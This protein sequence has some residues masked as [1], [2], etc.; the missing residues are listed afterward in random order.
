MN[1]SAILLSLAV[2][3]GCD[4]PFGPDDEGIVLT[5]DAEA[6]SPGA[7]ITGELRN[8]SSESIGYN[9][10]FSGFYRRRGFD[11]SSVS[12]LFG[13]GLACATIQLGLAPGATARFE[14]ALPSALTAGTYRLQ[15]E[16]ETREGRS[17]R[18]SDSFVIRTS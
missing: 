1:R 15:T 5:V 11:W 9:L 4:N 18:W 14:I 2:L 13:P 7:V 12:A 10:C 6:Y 17:S 8:E 16:V 3:T